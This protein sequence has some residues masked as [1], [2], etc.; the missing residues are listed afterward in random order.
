[1]KKEL[2]NKILLQTEEAKTFGLSK[3]ASNIEESISN[4]KDVSFTDLDNLV[5]KNLWNI[6]LNLIS[7]NEVESVDILKLEEVL[8]ELKEIIISNIENSIK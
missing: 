1:M 4:V 2:Y 3:L 8:D 5:E 6:A 7:Y